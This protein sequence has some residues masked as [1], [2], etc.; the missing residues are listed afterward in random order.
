MVNQGKRTVLSGPAKQLQKTSRPRRVRQSLQRSTWAK[1][2]PKEGSSVS[3]TNKRDFTSVAPFLTTNSDKVSPHVLTRHAPILA[4]RITNAG[5]QTP[6]CTQPA[7]S[8]LTEANSPR[9][10]RIQNSNTCP[11][12]PGSTVPKDSAPSVPQS[13]SSSKDSIPTGDNKAIKDPLV[14]HFES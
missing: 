6:P 9:S 12:S 7:V 11:P 13:V 10:L 2:H 5:A 1:S 8:E 3:L 14:E 4:T